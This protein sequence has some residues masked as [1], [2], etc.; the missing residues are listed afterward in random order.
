MTIIPMYRAFGTYRVA[1][2]SK[3]F[4]I[5]KQEYVLWNAVSRDGVLEAVTLASRILEA[6]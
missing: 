4:F 1:K 2:K 6:S 3:L 5:V